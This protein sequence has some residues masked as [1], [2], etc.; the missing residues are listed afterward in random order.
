MRTLEQR[1]SELETKVNGQQKWI[2]N[3]TKAIKKIITFITP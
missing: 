2:N 1:V 3:A